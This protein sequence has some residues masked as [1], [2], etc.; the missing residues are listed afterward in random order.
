MFGIRIQSLLLCCRAGNQQD[1][2]TPLTVG[3]AI[4]P[5][6]R[7]GEGALMNAFEKFGDFARK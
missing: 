3:V 5:I 4:Q 2:F 6:Q 1:E 7:F